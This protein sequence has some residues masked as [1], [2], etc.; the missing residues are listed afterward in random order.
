MR[1]FALTKTNLL[2]ILILIIFSIHLLSI[3]SHAEDKLFPLFPEIKNNVFFWQNVYSNY[4]TN[5][6]ILHDEKD[7]SIVYGV[8]ALLPKTT[9]DYREINKK[10]IDEAKKNYQNILKSLTKKPNDDNPEAKRI[11]TLFGSNAKPT[12]FLEAIRNIRCQIGQKDRF[13][14]GLER[15]GAYVDKISSILSSYNLPID[16]VHLPHVESSF[17]TKA[18]SKFGA[19][20]IW[21]FTLDTGR[22][23]LKIDYTLDERRDPVAASHAAALLLKE[24]YEKLKSWPLAITAYNHGSAGMQKAKRK[25]GDYPKIFTNY[26][27]RTFKFASRNFYP[28]FLAA[29]NVARSYGRFFGEVQFDSPVQ[30]HSIVLEGYT[31]LKDIIKVFGVDAATVAEL[32]PAIRLPVFKG[33]KYLPQG[34]RLHLPETINSNQN[35]IAAVILREYYHKKQKPSHFYTVRRGD[36]SW[37]IAR[38]HK[39]KLQDLLIAN[40]LHKNATIHVNQNLRIPLPEEHQ[41][42]LSSITQPP[43]AELLEIPKVPQPIVAAILPLSFGKTESSL[44]HPNITPALIAHPRIETPINPEIISRNLKIE[45]ILTEKN[46]IFGLIKVEV[47]ETLGHFADWLEIKTRILRQLNKLH[48]GRVVH[49]G[50]SLKIP[51]SRISKELFEKR[52]LDH[53][54]RLQEVFFSAYQVDSLQPYYV[55]KGENIW[56]ISNQKFNLPIWLIQQCNPSIDF[57]SLRHSQKLMIPVVEKRG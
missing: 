50:Q 7:L 44:Q 21:Q 3:P 52:R 35:K 31:A 15:S 6:C 18:Y 9:A 10:R 28:E 20:G 37:K 22:R 42:Q 39:V 57:H 51:L 29:R 24:N 55:R 1:H 16:L 26:Q 43:T 34:Y 12:I 48:Y 19:A 41:N 14:E 47:E 2:K 13:L 8:I 4:T 54:K 45:K 32:N 49:I 11:A 30:T 56:K 33:V 40:N 23:F 17:D 36:T 5:Q 53:H 38:L 25:W 27:S 46:K